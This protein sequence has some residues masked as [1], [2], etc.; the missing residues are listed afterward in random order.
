[1]RM[2]NNK[3]KRL[4]TSRDNLDFILLVALWLLSYLLL[5]YNIL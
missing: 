2:I 1:M 5:K 3:W 4:L